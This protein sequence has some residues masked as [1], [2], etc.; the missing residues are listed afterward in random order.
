MGEAEGYEK[1]CPKVCDIIYERSR[2]T[3][4]E[5][6]NVT[7]HI[8]PRDPIHFVKLSEAQTRRPGNGINP[9]NV[10]LDCKK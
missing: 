8:N 5:F 7:T 3:E 6:Y 9:I 10:C 2:R 1:N 4:H